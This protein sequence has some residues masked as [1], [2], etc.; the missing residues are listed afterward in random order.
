[1]RTFQPRP[2]VEQRVKPQW[3]PDNQRGRDQIKAWTG[4][5]LIEIDR[6]ERAA[7][8]KEEFIVF[9]GT[10]MRR[11]DLPVVFLETFALTAAE[12][13]DVTPLQ[14]FAKDFKPRWAPFIYLP[15]RSG[16]KGNWLPKNSPL[17]QDPALMA[18]IIDVLKIKAIWKQHHVKC[19]IAFAVDIAAERHGVTV[20]DLERAR[21]KSPAKK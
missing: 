18:A 2:T 19:K 9:H 13:G 15:R 4:A 12:Y 8:E 6:D 3:S 20:E 10:S 5:R 21:S 7:L 17:E 11:D 14:Q 16:K 1:M